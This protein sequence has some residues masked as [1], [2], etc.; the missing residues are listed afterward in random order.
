MKKIIKLNESQLNVLIDNIISE[1]G[2]VPRAYAEHW[3][4]KFEKS[5]DILLKIGYH[6]DELIKKIK[7]RTNNNQI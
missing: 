4:N 5:I 1:D 3:E 2:N 7:I 6:P